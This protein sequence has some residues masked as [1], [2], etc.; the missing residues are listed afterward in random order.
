MVVDTGE[1]PT[2]P[3]L[4]RPGD[5]LLGKAVLIHQD[6]QVRTV[7]RRSA[8]A[9]GLLA[10]AGA[11]AVATG[12]F[13]RGRRWLHTVGLVD[14]PDLPVPTAD[15]AV[16][17]QELASGHMPTPVY[18]SFVAGESSPATRIL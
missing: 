4:E 1:P 9:A 13:A 12:N 3:T 8:L 7:T 10:T 16:E 6:G 5:N 11:G 2:G 17:Y 18:R 14:G 15:V